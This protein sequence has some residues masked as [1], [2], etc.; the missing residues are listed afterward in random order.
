MHVVL[1]ILVKFCYMF[2]AKKILL[3]I[4]MMIQ[5]TGPIAVLVFGYGWTSFTKNDNMYLSRDAAVW[6]IASLNQFSEYSVATD[7]RERV[8][9]D[10]K[11][12]CLAILANS[13]KL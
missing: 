5:V 12:I 9:I 4:V 10:M 3:I 6:N 11:I 13:D 7:Y 1:T 2:P 8:I